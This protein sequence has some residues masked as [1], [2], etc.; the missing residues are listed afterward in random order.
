[1]PAMMKG[2]ARLIYW[3][4]KCKL[5]KPLWKSREEGSQKVTY[6]RTRASST[7]LG[8]AVCKGL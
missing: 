7:T 4:C 8:I 6:S 1:M 2:R 5:I 3:W